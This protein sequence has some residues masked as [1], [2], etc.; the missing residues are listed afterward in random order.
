MN[1]NEFLDALSRALTGKVSANEV[2]QHIAYYRDYIDKQIRLGK[3]EEEIINELGDPRLLVKSIVNAENA[4][5]EIHGWGSK[6]SEYTY[7][8]TDDDSEQTTYQSNRN[9]PKV[10]PWWLV[11][12]VIIV[13]VIAILSAI[14]SLVIAIF[15][16][17]LLLGLVIAFWLYWYMTRRR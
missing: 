17:P 6:T 3:S 13:I 15:S 9:T 16:S 1:K 5:S 2:S 11:I 12:L 7:E 10:I 4:A 8:A 14:G